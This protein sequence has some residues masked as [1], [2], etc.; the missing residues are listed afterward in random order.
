MSNII[1][2]KMPSLKEKHAGNSLCRSNHHQWKI[3]KENHFDTK[4]G[5]LITV[6]QC[7]RCKKK[8]NKAT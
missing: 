4:Q 8:K 3:I 5:K 2:F 7:S 1:K 6:W